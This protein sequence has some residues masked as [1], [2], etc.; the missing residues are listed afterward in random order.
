MTNFP[1]SSDMILTDVSDASGGGINYTF[2]DPGNMFRGQ[3]TRNV[4]EG[5]RLADLN[6][7]YSS[8]GTVIPITFGVRT[9]YGNVIWAAPLNELEYKNTETVYGNGG[10][11][12]LDLPGLTG[13]QSPVVQNVTHEYFYFADFAVSFGYGDPDNPDKIVLR[14]WADGRLIYDAR[15]PVD[16]GADDPLS[17]LYTP[18]NDFETIKF[19]FFPGTMTQ[20]PS[21]VIQRYENARYAEEHSTDPNVNV[22][23]AYLGQM[24][25]V[26]EQFPITPFGNNIPF[27]KIE[28]AD[29]TS[30]ANDIDDYLDFPDALA[31]TPQSAVIDWNNLLMYSTDGTS[32]RTVDLASLQ[33]IRSVPVT[34]VKADKSISGEGNSIAGLD[35][36]RHTG[37]L[38]AHTAAGEAI[39]IFNVNPVTGI[40][41]PL[42]S[43]G[44]KVTMGPY[45]A[46]FM[47]PYRLM[48]LSYVGI[49]GMIYDEIIVSESSG[50]TKLFSS[51]A[52]SS[53]FLQ[54]HYAGIGL[55]EEYTPGELA[56]N[57]GVF[58]YNF[59]DVIWRIQGDTQ[60]NFASGVDVSFFQYIAS[61]NA[62]LVCYD[63]GTD[64]TFH[65]IDVVT[66]DPIW[67]SEIV[68]GGFANLTSDALW[69]MD[70]RGE[71]MLFRRGGAYTMIDLSNGALIKEAVAIYPNVFPM[72]SG[73]FRAFFGAESYYFIDRPSAERVS[74]GD[75]IRFTANLADL[76][77]TGPTAQ[78]IVDSTI[79]DIIIDGAYLNEARKRFRQ[80]L[81]E[82][83]AAFIFDVRESN[84]QIVCAK[85]DP[86]DAT[87]DFSFYVKNM[88]KLDDGNPEA[89]QV[90]RREEDGIPTLVE[91]RFLDYV[92][93]YQEN[94]VYAQREGTS[95][96][97]TSVSLR[98]PIIMR[99]N[100]AKVW[101]YKVLYNE[102]NTRET[103]AVRV[104]FGEI[105]TEP[106]DV[107]IINSDGRIYRV[108]VERVI[109]N[110][111][112]SMSI[113]F[114]NYVDDS[115]VTIDADEPLG[116]VPTLQY[117]SPSTAYMFDLPDA[118]PTD[119]DFIR[120]DRLA[121]LLFI[122][123]PDVPE[124]LW[125]GA[126]LDIQ[127]IYGTSW[128]YNFGPNL[129]ET[130]LLGVTLS[131]LDDVTGTEFSIDDTSELTV[132]THPLLTLSTITDAEFFSG[133]K[134][135]A[136]IRTF[137]GCELVIFRDVE[138]LG[139]NEYKLTH[140]LR[141]H[142]GTERQVDQ[143]AQS[144]VILFLIPNMQA[145]IPI[146][147]RAKGTQV[148]VR[149]RT[150]GRENTAATSKE[151]AQGYTQLPF[152][153]W[154]VAATR[155]EDGNIEITW[156][157]RTRA[158]ATDQFVEDEPEAELP[159]WENVQKF[160]IFFP[161]DDWFVVVEP[162]P[163]PGAPAYATN[164]GLSLFDDRT[165][166]RTGLD[167]HKLTL[168]V[169]DQVALFGDEITRD[170]F[171]V[172][173][174]QHSAEWGRG[175]G[176]AK[177][178]Y[179]NGDE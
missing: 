98:V 78:L 36:S 150:V 87:N 177:E 4:Y 102:W 164:P 3:L 128:T 42:K 156:Q 74:L 6:V 51:E 80:L 133:Q 14:I 160:E 55:A 172:A 94:V 53:P 168:T 24:Y 28:L 175:V 107:G 49:N 149:A 72:T 37:L 73:R 71:T 10:F 27:I 117:F 162:D 137:Q 8:Y 103:F 132:R 75:F 89:L 176:K 122:A 139:D 19:K 157:Q 141:G 166:G 40:C 44:G 48:V 145:V 43:Y 114:K 35:I 142:R 69:K 54:D 135:V 105:K 83:Q 129:I 92:R 31:Y 161:V 143:H 45:N 140:F 101:A 110:S 22:V 111:E 61:K 57:R 63:D 174:F 59:D 26:F 16:G 155:D 82:L 93:E 130:R 136:A 99:F 66:K 60:E 7:H 153:P 178:V 65:L 50:G 68:D 113:A 32:I 58:Y 115:A 21:A 159:S 12:S 118:F 79:D 96:S 91:Y 169:A 146:D 134:N 106:S 46:S 152:Q 123:T 18:V 119:S 158:P 127:T 170:R 163:I 20:E 100:E 11:P 138:N 171:N 2:T 124:R 144:S 81:D 109:Y 112:W 15:G 29:A 86:D 30:I 88:L 121:K 23:P 85:R 41:V 104:G 116:Y 1:R 64:A 154:G 34:R 165:E 173:V 84:G 38:Y 179:I 17:P 62:L 5:P 126:L 9:L 77:T 67:I 147:A 33:F 76:T 125:K 95:L 90:E 148:T 39:Q 131:A 97:D 70:T 108:K 13:S 47:T 167:P 52:D 120:D 25:I 151:I 56:P